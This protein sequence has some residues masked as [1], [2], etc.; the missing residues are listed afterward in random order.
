MSFGC[1]HGAICPAKLKT[2]GKRCPRD[3]RALPADANPRPARSLGI[4]RLPCPALRGA[5]GSTGHQN[6]LGFLSLSALFLLT[7]GSQ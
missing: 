6:R 2:Q 3:S 4:A 5:R 7:P 1:S